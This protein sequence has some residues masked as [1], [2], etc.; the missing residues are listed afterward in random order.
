MY[1]RRKDLDKF[2]LQK[3]AHARI[4]WQV[5]WPRAKGREDWRLNID[6]LAARCGHKVH[7]IN[8]GAIITDTN[9]SKYTIDPPTH[10]SDWTTVFMKY[11]DAVQSHKLAA[12]PL[13]EV[14]PPV[15]SRPVPHCLQE[16]FTPADFET[17][18]WDTF[19]K[20]DMDL[21]LRRLRAV[22]RSEFLRLT[23]DD[24]IIKNAGILHGHT[25]DLMLAEC[26]CGRLIVAHSS[27]LN[28]G[29]RYWP[30]CGCQWGDKGGYTGNKRDT[31]RGAW[32]EW[33][34]MKL[35]ATEEAAAL[36][37]LLALEGDTMTDKLP[38]TFKDFWRWY[39][40]EALKAKRL[41][42]Q[43]IDPTGPFSVDN[44]EFTPADKKPRLIVNPAN[45]K[46]YKVAI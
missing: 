12:P 21:Q 3:R 40:Y 29:A 1:F 39:S 25:T 5:D 33:C 44:L 7:L 17:T 43:R 2:I 15:D 20:N 36:H 31:V 19:N 18:P 30:T 8:G 13:D 32:R 26:S 23:A 10:A 9:G 42:L 35:L 6:T 22:P 16:N 4:A 41:Y 46:K 27:I 45:A 37:Q 11:I 24:S 38:A 34:T 28:K 14:F